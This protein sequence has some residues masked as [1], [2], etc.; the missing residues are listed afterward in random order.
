[1]KKEFTIKSN[2]K[3]VTIKEY[4]NIINILINE[5]FDEVEKIDN[6]I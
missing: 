6:I 4:F 3:Q 1:M 2:W 5:D